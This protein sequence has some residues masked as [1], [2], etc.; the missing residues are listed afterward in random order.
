MVETSTVDG[1][2]GPAVAPRG[3]CR[4]R[5]TSAAFTDAL[6]NCIDGGDAPHHD[7]IA[8]GSVEQGDHRRSEQ[9][10]ASWPKN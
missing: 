1:E 8:C 4:R 3:R 2:A 5:G 6:P 7:T 10:D 9:P